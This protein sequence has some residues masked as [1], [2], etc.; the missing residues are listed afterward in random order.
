VDI[1]LVTDDREV[2]EALGDLAPETVGVDVERSDGEHYFRSAALIQIGYAGA[3]VVVDPLAD[4]DLGILA[5]ALRGRFVVL[6]AVENDLEPL[7][8]VDVHLAVDGAPHREIADTAIAAALLGLPTGLGPLL[9]DVLEVRLTAD[10]ERFQR[11]DWTRRPLP[12]DMLEYAAG[13]VIHLPHLWSELETRLRAT[14]RLRWYEEELQQTVERAREDRRSWRRTR[15]ADRLDGRARAVLR[16]L[17]EEREEI[18]RS[19]DIAPQLVTRDDALVTLAGDPPA[20]RGDLRA[21]GVRGRQVRE[22]GER[23]LAATR[24]GIEADEVESLS[25]VRPATDDDRSVHDRLRRARAGVAREIG[26]DPGVLCP[27]RVLWQ[28]V[29]ADPRDADE[30]CTAAELRPWQRELLADVL[31]DAYTEG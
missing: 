7:D 5:D 18:A 10:K 31:W 29:L 22:H 15:G 16:E 6:H 1:R 21:R 24:R 13:D 17:W 4:V 28:A 2:A 20:T 8:D 19:E 14:E 26:V 27:N 23:L 12:G 9:A 30:L 11:A 25:G 3:C